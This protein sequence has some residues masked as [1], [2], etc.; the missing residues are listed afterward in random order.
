MYSLWLVMSVSCCNDDDR[1]AAAVPAPAP[2]FAYMHVPHH[3]SILFPTHTCACACMQTTLHMVLLFICLFVCGLMWCENYHATQIII[4][5]QNFLRLTLFVSLAIAM[6]LSRPLLWLSF[7]IIHVY[8][9]VGRCDLILVEP[10][11][12]FILQTAT[13]LNAR[14]G[15]VRW[16][17]VFI[18]HWKYRVGVDEKKTHLYVFIKPLCK[19]NGLLDTCNC[20]EWNAYF[21]I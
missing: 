18:S 9:L 1:A 16:S 11:S 12:P 17:Q 20:T 14:H 13:K 8:T 10:I 21:T 5:A 19:Y 15:E 3:N 2:L 4:V 7:H 6:C